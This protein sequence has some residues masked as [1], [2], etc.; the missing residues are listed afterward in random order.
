MRSFLTLFGAAVCLFFSGCSLG[1]RD[2]NQPV[3]I[4]VILPLTGPD[5]E[6]GKNML[7]G[8]R[9]ARAAL[10][11]QDG[12]TLIPEL[13]TGDNRGLPED[14][15]LAALSMIQQGA[16]ALIVGYS[17][18]EALAVKSL[19]AEYQ[20]PVIT[21]GGSN[22]RITENN[23]YMFRVNFSDRQQAKLLASYAR[24]VRRMGRMAVML[25][26]DENAVYSR[27]LGRQ[28]AQ[29]FAD[30]GGDII[31]AVGFRETDTDF[32]GAVQEL[33]RDVPDVIFV[34]A[35]PACAA[36][37]IR[38]LR[39]GGF[40]GLILGGDSWYSEE[41]LRECGDPGDA[42]LGSIYAADGPGVS[43]QGF[44]KLFAER[45]HCPPTESDVLGYDAMILA[46]TGV[47]GTRNSQE[48]LEKFARIRE[49]RGALGNIPLEKNGNVLRKAYM[50]K[51]VYQ[52]P[53]P[54]QFRYETVM[55]PEPPQL[56]DELR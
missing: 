52:A 5:S 7:R 45:N 32:S 4:G 16:A 22:D 29:A 28:T 56:P 31:A 38:A 18:Q 20:I 36:K 25:N 44:Y 53:G 35:F 39:Q 21:P 19:A 12:A 3:K 13:L 17:S 11:M 41:L 26:L 9:C 43:R 48:A 27:D 6:C 2:V 51:L 37:I 10:S 46:A 40:K 8:V 30:Y 42:V 33:L 54:A 23:P 50:S 24:H 1:E 49:F 55:Q 14:T 34:P 15:R 47:M